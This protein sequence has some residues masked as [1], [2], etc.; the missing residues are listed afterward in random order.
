M[1]SKLV[2]QTSTPKLGNE[3]IQFYEF[4]SFVPV[5]KH[6]TTNAKAWTKP[7]KKTL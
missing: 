6:F 2:H 3:K 5:A 7:S 4:V 1:E